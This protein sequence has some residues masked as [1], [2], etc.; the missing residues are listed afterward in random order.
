MA[1]EEQQ[2][3]SKTKDNIEQVP[4]ILNGKR[5]TDD[6]P[7]K[8]LDGGGGVEHRLKHTRYYVPEQSPPVTESRDLSPSLGDC[9]SDLKTN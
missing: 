7:R 9:H 6:K 8:L 5:I 2:Q 3:K 4:K 1:G